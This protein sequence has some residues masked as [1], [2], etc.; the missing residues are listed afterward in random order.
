MRKQNLQWSWQSWQRIRSGLGYSCF[1]FGSGYSFIRIY[2]SEFAFGS[3]PP[4]DL[5]KKSAIYTA[6]T[7]LSLPQFFFL[8]LHLNF[9]RKTPQFWLKSFFCLLLV[10]VIKIKVYLFTGRSAADLF[11]LDPE[12]FWIFKF[13]DPDTSGLWWR[14]TCHLAHS[15]T[16]S[17][18]IFFMERKGI[19]ENRTSLH[20]DTVFLTEN[21]IITENNHNRT[22]ITENKTSLHNNKWHRLIRVLINIPL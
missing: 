17:E 3:A 16:S 13:V 14:T 5:G 11:F 15:N 8:G 12:R 18:R 10:F 2:G 22:T 1:F 6:K 9:G 20:N 19:T 21:R 4:N 7:L